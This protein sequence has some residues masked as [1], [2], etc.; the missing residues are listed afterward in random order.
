M[1]EL[2]LLS[3][4]ALDRDLH[5][6]IAARHHDPIT[7]RE[8]FRQVAQGALA[9]DLGY[10]KWRIAQLRGKRTGLLQ[11]GC[12]FDKRNADPIYPQR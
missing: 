5:P 12:R 4:Y 8:N 6:Q 2:L 9:L 10:Q 1:N 3:G 7:S 11:I